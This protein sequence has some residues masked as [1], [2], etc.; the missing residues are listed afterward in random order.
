[1]QNQAERYAARG[2]LPLPLVPGEKRPWGRAW[3]TI[4]HETRQERWAAAPAG[5][6]LGLLTGPASG[7]VVVDLD[8]PGAAEADALTWWAAQEAQHGACA[9]PTVCTGSG[10]RHLYFQYTDDLP[11]RLRRNSA[12]LLQ[13]QQG[14]PISLDIRA[15]GGQVVAPP[16]VVNGRAY[17]WA[18]G[19]EGLPP[20]PV[21]A[22]LRLL[23]ADAPAD[24]NTPPA[25]E[26]E[27]DPDEA[28]W[29]LIGHA[30]PPP[31]RLDDRVRLAGAT[32]TLN[33][34]LVYLVLRHL[35]PRHDCAG[36][37]GRLNNLKALVA[38]LPAA[39]QEAY[40]AAQDRLWSR[41]GRGYDATHNRA[42]WRELTGA[43]GNFQVL[44]A[45]ARPAL[46]AGPGLAQLQAACVPHPEED[47]DPPGADPPFPPIQ[48]PADGFTYQHFTAPAY[49]DRPHTL[50][51]L[52][53]DLVRCIARVHA[54]GH[55]TWYIRSWDGV[56][57]PTLVE[58]PRLYAEGDEE[59]YRVQ[60]APPTTL[61]K[62][63]SC[64]E[65]RAA[66]TFQARDVV[67]YPPGHPEQAHRGREVRT[68]NLFPGWACQPADLPDEA[69]AAAAAP[70]VDHLSEVWCAGDPVLTEYV[71]NWF[72][73]L[74]QHP[75]K[76]AGTALV[77]R[78]RQ[79][80]GKNIIADWFGKYVL[81]P[82]LYLCTPDVEEV[83][84][85]FN[86]TLV[87]RKLVVLNEAAIG[88]DAAG[89]R[90]YNDAL[91]SRVT[92]ETLSVNPKGLAR[93]T[94]HDAAAYL[95]F[96]NHD[97]PVRVASD[98]RRYV[99]LDCAGHRRGDRAYFDELVAGL[100]AEGAAAAV[101]TLLLRRNLQAW[102]PAH[103]P[104]TAL[105]QEL[106]QLGACQAERYLAAEDEAHAAQAEDEAP[107]PAP[108]EI[109]CGDLYPRY[110][111]WA[112]DS[113][114]RPLPRA[115]LTATLRRLERVE[116]VRARA[117]GGRLHYVYR[118]TPQ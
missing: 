42:I 65:I 49:R 113:G 111:A 6:G 96:S 60:D 99:C 82:R 105:A 107:A 12:R 22:W 50:P 81:G 45:E 74:L 3:Q 104:R 70:F 44:L 13:D 75:A 57:C 72:A 34:R 93:Y 112:A 114:E 68:L 102:A 94:V 25:A 108:Y 27:E 15:A 59:V 67:P 85:R 86:D 8:H 9:A 117:A 29:A 35:P 38:A 116:R 66:A 30:E 33:Q 20:P 118:V 64:A 80:A 16:T 21:P 100:H 14:R 69:L 101:M 43:A 115:R 41:R 88:G 71:L 106:R 63:L 4:T 52:Q 28:L 47:A 11:A 2:W 77:L 54:H 110:L 40:Y 7:L 83:L 48:D 39:E 10:G 19:T 78:S 89:W 17:A 1:M 23:Y 97:E 91:K 36:W 73:Y 58:A 95:I 51:E 103:L 46:E 92:E 62:L 90:A 26:P 79:G 109:P 61:K 84:G 37:M 56:S 5:A 55:K 98:D 76:K 53:A 31:L 87:G 24:D 32:Y 18:A